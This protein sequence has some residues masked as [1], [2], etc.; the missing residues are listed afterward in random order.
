MRSVLLAALL[1]AIATSPALA[2]QGVTA[3]DLTQNPAR[4]YGKIIRV[5]GTITAYQA[6]V[7]ARGTPYATF[8]LTE[9]GASVTVFAGRPRGLRNTLYVR[10]TGKFVKVRRVGR[11]T[12]RDAVE[13]VRIE[14]LR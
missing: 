8:R 11:D 12:F 14:V 4:H 10:V 6:R 13:A 7:S 2:Q 3:W 1:V 5:T 9:G